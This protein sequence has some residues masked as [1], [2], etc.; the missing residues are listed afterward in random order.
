MNSVNSVNKVDPKK[1]RLTN[2]MRLPHS[3]MRRGGVAGVAS[4]PP[5][6]GGKVHGIVHQ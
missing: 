6:A 3:D 5:P 2:R 4:S 1:G